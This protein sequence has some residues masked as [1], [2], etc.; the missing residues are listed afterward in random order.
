MSKSKLLVSL[1]T[2]V[3]G[4][5]L[6]FSVDAQTTNRSFFIN[7]N[8]VLQPVNSAWV[9]GD[10]T[11]PIADGKFTALTIDTL[12]VGSLSTGAIIIDVD[13]DEAFLVRKDGD[14]GDVFL[15]DTNNDHVDFS[16]VDVRVGDGSYS[17]GHT[18]DF[19]VEGVVEFDGAVYFDST[20]QIANN[21]WL[22][23]TDN[24]GTGTVNMF[25][26]NTDD[27]IDLG[28]QMN[29]GVYTLAADSGEGAVAIDEPCSDSLGD[30][31]FCGYALSV[32][33]N[34][35]VQIYALADGSGG[36]TE[37]LFHNKVGLAYEPSS[38]QSLSDDGAVD[39]S[40]DTV[41][42]VVGD[43]G[44][45][46]LDADPA[47]VDGVLDGQMCII[48]GTDDT[49]TVQIMDAVNT[50]FA[51]ADYTFAS[52]DVMTIMWWD[53]ESEWIQVGEFMDN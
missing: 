45:A 26:V 34:G 52:G 46:V 28:A 3:V 13:A 19:G 24:A 11:Y 44:A 9:I 12:T 32:D 1:I 50:A 18:P 35:F 36:T 8:G 31:D 43:G 23:G 40:A 49:N 42:R 25:K 17:F 41:V 15:V 7:R 51:S 14:G 48:Q 10:A 21:T 16:S 53:A 37:R 22:L 38:A 20:A 2:L 27:E 30:G 6:G 5:T 39:C 33:S 4:I 47:I 29:V